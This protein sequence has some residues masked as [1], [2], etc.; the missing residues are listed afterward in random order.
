MRNFPSSGFPRP[1]AVAI[2]TSRAETYAV[3]IV[4]PDRNSIPSRTPLGGGLHS[5]ECASHVWDRDRPSSRSVQRLRDVSCLPS[6][7]DDSYTGRGRWQHGPADNGAGRDLLN[8]LS[9]VTVS[10]RTELCCC[11]ISKFVDISK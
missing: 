2:R 1:I 9:R 10:V 5:V 11:L 4:S 3:C 8:L 7:A 6:F